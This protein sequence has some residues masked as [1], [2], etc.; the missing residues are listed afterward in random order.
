MTRQKTTEDR[1]V[2]NE[3]VTGHVC[4]E[5]E[6]LAARAACILGSRF[7][8]VDLITL[9]PTLPLDKTG[10]VINEINT[11]PGLHHHYGLIND[12]AS[13]AVEV[14]KHLLQVPGDG[15]QQ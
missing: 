15:G 5:I 9:D 12:N 8:G 11:T 14:L 10:G 13:P 4:R 7:A 2:F 6:R 1:T 3:N